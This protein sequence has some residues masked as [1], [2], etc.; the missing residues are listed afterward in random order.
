MARR[1]SKLNRRAI[2]EQK[3]IKR[4]QQ[5]QAKVFQDFDQEDVIESNTKIAVT[6]GMWTAGTTGSLKSGAF[7]TSSGQSSTQ[8]YYQVYSDSLY[9]QPEFSVAYGNYF[10]SS[11]NSGPIN[12]RFR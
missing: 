9:T 11:S 12:S 8:Y 3:S 5:I 4:R 10:G 2:A 1:L 6:D 7:Y